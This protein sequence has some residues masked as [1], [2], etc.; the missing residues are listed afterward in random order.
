MPLNN[1][2]AI[3]FLLTLSPVVFVVLVISIKYLKKKVDN[4]RSSSFIQRSRF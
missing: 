2:L 3:S 4:T 1:N